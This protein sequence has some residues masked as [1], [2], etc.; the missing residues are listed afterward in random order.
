MFKAIYFLKLILVLLEKAILQ[1]N[2]PTIVNPVE[3]TG[4][5]K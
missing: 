1:K 4:K 3:S 2:M 5:K